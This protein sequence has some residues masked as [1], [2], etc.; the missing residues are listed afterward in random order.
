MSIIDVLAQRYKYS[1][2]A[3]TSGSYYN[4]GR[5]NYNEKEV[6]ANFNN[7]WTKGY[8]TVAD[9]NDFISNIEKYNTLS[10]DKS[11][12]LKGEAIA[13]RAMIHFDLLRLFGPIYST[14]SEDLAIPYKVVLEA[15]NSVRLPASQVIELILQDLTT[16]EELLKDDVIRQGSKGATDASFYSDKRT[17]R[18][19]YFAVKALQ[20]RVLLYA[21][22]NTEANKAAK[23]VINEASSFFPWTDYRTEI[24]D[25]KDPDRI[26]SSEVILGVENIKLYDRQR[27][28]FDASIAESS[29]LV[30][31]DNNRLSLVFESQEDDYR[32]LTT[33]NKAAEKSYLTFFKFADVV[34]DKKT[35]RYI[36]PLI[37]I[38]EMYYIAAETETNNE[39]A[40]RYLNTVRT[41]RGLLA[42]L[43]SNS[44][45]S[46]EIQ[47][48]YQKEFFGEGQL[49][50][51]YKR[52]NVLSILNGASN[53]F[54]TMTSDQYVVPLPDS[55]INF[56]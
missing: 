32:Y 9:I 29:I 50:F 20:A 43:D 21:G 17:T 51:Y 53:S 35:F 28:Y 34:D 33:W 8:K 52:K 4:Y 55:E 3:S 23:V 15:Q 37:R 38:S 41:N 7:I 6:K 40:L 44:N 42:E 11:N 45:L 30:P 10:T 27:K 12:L 26:F 1:A 13:L 54:I 18:F 31:L 46:Q 24:N 25:S 2:F 14:N 36:Q 48:E 16:A 56:Q 39:E 22:K 5:Y 47:K 19:N 49:F